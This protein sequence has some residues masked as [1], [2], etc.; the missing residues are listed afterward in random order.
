VDREVALQQD[1][2]EKQT[3]E[4]HFDEDSPYAPWRAFEFVYSG[5]YSADIDT[6]GGSGRLSQLC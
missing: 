1:L 5:K 3:R 2:L 4:F 6:L